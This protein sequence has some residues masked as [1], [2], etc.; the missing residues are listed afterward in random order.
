MTSTNNNGANS[1]SPALEKQTSLSKLN[2]MADSVVAKINSFMSSY[3]PML[4]DF[5]SDNNRSLVLSCLLAMV[6]LKYILLEGLLSM[7][8]P[9]CNEMEYLETVQYLPNPPPYSKPFGEQEVMALE[10]SAVILLAIANAKANHYL[11]LVPALGVATAS[12]VIATKQDMDNC[13]T[14]TK[15]DYVLKIVAGYSILMAL[16]VNLAQWIITLL[17]NL[18]ALILLLSELKN[19]LFQSA[20]QAVA[21]VDPKEA[22]LRKMVAVPFRLYIALSLSAAIILVFYGDSMTLAATFI[23]NMNAWAPGE[24]TNAITL[25]IYIGLSLGLVYVAAAII[26]TI[27]AHTQLSEEMYQNILKT[28]PPFCTPRTTDKIPEYIIGVGPDSGRGALFVH[29]AIQ[30]TPIPLPPPK[31]P[32]APKCQLPKFP[33]SKNLYE[34]IT[35]SIVLNESDLAGATGYIGFF[36]SSYLLVY[37]ILCIATILIL[38]CFIWSQTRNYIIAAVIGALASVPTKFIINLVINLFV[39]RYKLHIQF[40][41][42]YML[43]DAVISFTLGLFVGIFSALGR[44]ITSF[45]VSIFMLFFLHRPSLPYSLAKF[46]SGFK[47]HC[48]MMK[49]R[50]VSIISTDLSAVLP[51]VTL[52]E[53]STADNVEIGINPM[54][55][56]FPK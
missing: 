7:H 49:A 46:D 52:S 27:K 29:P 10:I 56:S 5:V 54:A 48:S 16:L 24:E 9:S 20:S 55:P 34:V 43:A 42:L 40:P 19:A 17:T 30:Y 11:W 12:S 18:I 1:N 36:V 3:V 45:F 28:A 33:P 44:I 22:K 31:D 2:D 37:I 47:Q 41:S 13:I 50:Y 51:V 25:S 38:F 4:G 21:S 14:L 32:N 35:D 39:V 15:M 8:L 23:A 6:A 26:L 53:D